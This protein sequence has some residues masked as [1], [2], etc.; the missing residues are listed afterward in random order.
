MLTG[1]YYLLLYELVDD[2]MDR[3][4]AF[5]EEHLRLARD[6]NERG[7][8]LLAG[9]YANPPDG[10]ALVFRA[11]DDSTVRDFVAHDPYVRER[12]VKQWTIRQWTVVIGEQ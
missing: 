8:L 2:Y 4:P 1:V 6:L 9:A 3:R 5:R 10:A 7:A 12:L 11:D